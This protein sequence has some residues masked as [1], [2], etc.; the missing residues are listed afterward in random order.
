MYLGTTIFF[1]YFWDP[2]FTLVNNR[3][4]FVVVKQ[5][6]TICLCIL[7]SFSIST[8]AVPWNSWWNSTFN[9][10]PTKMI[11][12]SLSVIDTLQAQPCNSAS[13]HYLKACDSGLNL[14]FERF[15]S[16]RIPKRKRKLKEGESVASLMR[17]LCNFINFHQAKMVGKSED[18][19]AAQGCWLKGYEQSLALL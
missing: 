9:Q 14:L 7:S 10:F 11:E 15:E 3:G 13:N 5:I 8:L 4:N 6:K 2:L 19:L 12:M 16:G 1:L 17:K 18:C